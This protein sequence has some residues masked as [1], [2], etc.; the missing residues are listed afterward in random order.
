MPDNQTCEPW[1][2]RERN[3]PLSTVLNFAPEGLVLGVGTVL[4]RAEGPRRLQSLA[5]REAQ[6]VALLSAAYGRAVTPSVL[7]NIER[8]AKAWREGDDCLAY[9]H[10][11]HGRLGELQHPPTPPSAS[12]LS[13]PS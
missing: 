6:V 7:G 12:S 9:M 3:V 11:A 13:T 4:L 2:M 5:G 10:L 8:A 1:H